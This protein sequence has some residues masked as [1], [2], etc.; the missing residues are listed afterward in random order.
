MPFVFAVTFFVP[1]WNISIIVQTYT[2]QVYNYH[3]WYIW[4]IRYLYLLA[5]VSTVSITYIAIFSPYLEAGLNTYTF[6][7]TPLADFVWVTVATLV[8]MVQAWLF[9]L[10]GDSMIAFRPDFIPP[11][12]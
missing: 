9:K 1:V 2:A 5:A 6:F 12:Y 3:K 4:P 8:G 7:K 10:Y 11:K